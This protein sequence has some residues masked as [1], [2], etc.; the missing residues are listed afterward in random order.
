MVTP[1]PADMP[2]YREPSR[3]RPRITA[4]AWQRMGEM[5][6][7]PEDVYLAYEQPGHSWQGRDN[8]R[9]YARDGIVVVV[10]HDETGPVVITVMPNTPH[11]RFQR[12]EADMP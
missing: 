6:V 11:G 5:R 10:F 7:Q 12:P 4:H 9:L 3:P 1:T 2:H 8:E